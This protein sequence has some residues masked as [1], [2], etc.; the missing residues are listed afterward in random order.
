MRKEIKYLVFTS[1]F[2]LMLLM[3]AGAFEGILQTVV[4]ILA[5]LVPFFAC[6]YLYF[7]DKSGEK[8][9]SPLYL[10]IGKNGLAITAA[11]LPLS[12]LVIL[13]SSLGWSFLLGL[14]GLSRV[15]VIEEEP[16][17][18]LCLHALLPALLEEGVFRYL[19]LRL[20]RRRSPRSTVLISAMLFAL[21]HHSVYSIP[22]AFVAGVVFMTADIMTDSVIPSLVIHFVN[23]A[24]ALLAM[25]AL[26]VNVRLDNLVMALILIS[27]LSVIPIFLK[28]KEIAAGTRL[29]FSRGEGRA[30]LGDVLYLA[31][32][33]ILIAIL[34]I[35]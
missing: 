29:A 16:L 28:R 9:T 6:L 27:L 10:K 17:L 34:E 25:G 3:F 32:P 1:L 2:T 12:V 11:I 22:Y 21:L 26:G 30:P 15:T 18:A 13:L 24:V 20:L 33:G 31:I 4:Y 14:F 5:F 19:P 8:I 23:N 35:W 7:G